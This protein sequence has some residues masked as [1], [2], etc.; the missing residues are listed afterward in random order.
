[1]RRSG[2][3]LLMGRMVMKEMSTDNRECTSIL[4]CF[5]LAA[6]SLLRPCLPL[7]LFLCR[8]T[9]DKWYCNT[10]IGSF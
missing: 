9:C 10:R 4:L 2:L 7:L 3:N 5:C 6:M 1:M 8:G